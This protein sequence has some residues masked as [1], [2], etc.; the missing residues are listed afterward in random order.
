MPKRLVGISYLYGVP[1][2][3][4]VREA[5]PSSLPNPLNITMLPNGLEIQI[6]H[7][8]KHHTVGLPFSDIKRIELAIPEDIVTKQERSIIGRAVIGGLLL[9]PVGAIVGG[10]SGLKD[11]TK[12]KS[13]DALLTFQ[14]EQA[15]EESFFV[16]AVEKSK[17]AITQSFLQKHLAQFLN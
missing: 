3:D 11:G 1:E 2:L 9:G 5:K 8:F 16:G 10:M 4:S 13:G 17:R 15:G 7:K 12:T 14:I 6:M